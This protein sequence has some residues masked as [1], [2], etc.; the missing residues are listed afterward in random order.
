M[1]TVVHPRARAD[2]EEG[3]PYRGFLYVSLMLTADGPRSSSSTCGW[4]TRRRRSRCRSSTARSPTLW[5]RPRRAA[6]GRR[7]RESGSHRGRHD[8]GARISGH[9]RM[10]TPFGGIARAALRAEDVMVF[11]AGTRAVGDAI[12]TAGGRVVT[13]SAAGRRATQRCARVRGVSSDSFDGMQFRRDIGR[14]VHGLPALTRRLTGH[15]RRTLTSD[16]DGI[17]FGRADHVGA[18]SRR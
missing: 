7:S 11:H 14:K 6:A 1:T 15:D 17:R 4:A 18:R 2:A 3:V 8:G 10:A 9:V 5:R 16:S 13:S 12:V